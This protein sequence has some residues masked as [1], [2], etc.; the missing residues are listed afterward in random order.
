MLLTGGVIA[1]DRV[2]VAV[3]QARRDRGA[4]GVDYRV[5]LGGVQILGMA[6][7][8]DPTVDGNDAV[9]VQDRFLKLA[10]QQQADIPDNEFARLAGHN[11]LSTWIIRFGTNSLAC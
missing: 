7:G 3:D 10:G 11:C 2:D 9:T 6:D 1:D 4:H 8:G 5:R